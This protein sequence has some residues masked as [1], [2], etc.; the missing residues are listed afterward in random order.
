MQSTLIPVSLPALTLC[1]AQRQIAYVRYLVHVYDPHSGRLLGSSPW[2]HGSS[3][4]NQ[5]TVFF[6]INFRGTDLRRLHCDDAYSPAIHQSET[7]L[8]RF[9]SSRP[10]SDV[11]SMQI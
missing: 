3:Y 7:V 9:T 1:E 8:N 2:Y 6:F 10:Y 5:Y 4:Y 11:R